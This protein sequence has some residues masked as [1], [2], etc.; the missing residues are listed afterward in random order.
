MLPMAIIAAATMLF[1]WPKRLLPRAGAAR[2]SRLVRACG[3]PEPLPGRDHSAGRRGLEPLAAALVFVS[4]FRSDVAIF[5]QGALG[6]FIGTFV[7]YWW[8]RAR[9]ESNFLWRVPPNSSQSGPD[10]AAD[11]ILQASLEI[12]ADSIIA[13]ALMFSFLGGSL[14]AG[15]WFTCLR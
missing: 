10:R 13:S 3:F 8:H 15:T 14:E 12:A 1:F 9:H 6:W 7:F 5:G 11:G 4:Y 2:G